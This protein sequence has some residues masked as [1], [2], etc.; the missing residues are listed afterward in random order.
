MTEST[1]S[2]T[3]FMGCHAKYNFKYNLRL[4]SR[5]L[6]EALAYGSLVH[7]YAETKHG[8]PNNAMVKCE[9]SLIEAYPEKDDVI[10]ALAFKA[11]CIGELWQ[12][13]WDDFDGDMSNKNLEFLMAEHEWKTGELVGKGDGYLHHKGY[14]KYFYYELKTA[15]R[16][17][18]ELYL[19]SL[20]LNKQV[21]VNINALWYM[22]KQC[23]GAFY[24][25]I[26]KPMIRKK[27]GETD[28]EF[29]ER[30]ID[31][32]RTEPAKYFDRQF[33]FRTNEDLVR[34]AKEMT[35]AIEYIKHV[36]Y[37]ARDDRAFFRNT[38]ECSKFGSQCQYHGICM[39]NN[40]HLQESFGTRQQKHPE[41]SN[42]PEMQGESNGDS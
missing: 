34:S 41:L 40:D 27:K 22:E 7:A 20:Q 19:S 26:W 12:A 16:I 11:R 30:Y 18:T 5:E 28:A 42:T 32:Y 38:G 14:D 6:R 29:E 23:D 21:D 15:S 9:E 35:S 39:E 31:C 3:T 37:V 17:T 1:S 33:V 25:I 2:I 36:N 4:D 8:G 24:D 13:Y 10:E